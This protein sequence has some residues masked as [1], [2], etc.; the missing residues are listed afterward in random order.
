MKKVLQLMVIETSKLGDMDVAC[1]T[2]NLSLTKS[3]F[4]LK[5]YNLV[6][7]NIDNKFYSVW[8]LTTVNFV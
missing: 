4:F 1:V 7:I 3:N 8:N 2:E 5:S 6:Y